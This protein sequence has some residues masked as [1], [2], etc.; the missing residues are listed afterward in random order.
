MHT[1][2]PNTT[3]KQI[4]CLSS[5]LMGPPN[6]SQNSVSSLFSAVMRVFL[7]YRR[8]TPLPNDEDLSSFLVEIGYEDTP[9]NMGDLKK[10]K[11]PAPWHMVVHYVLR[12]LS[13]KTGGTD[14]IVKDLLRL[15]WGVYRNKNIDFVGIL[16]NDFKQFVLAKKTE[17][18]SARFWSVI[19][20]KIYADHPTIAP[21][22]DD[23][24]YKAPLLSKY[25]T[26]YNRNH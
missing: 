22:E 6:L 16:W 11:F 7:S 21:A 26:N 10:A 25:S 23:V 18:P 13:E 4:L 19:L 1:K 2:R 24:M 15:L 14:T 5:W 8:C 9:P 3:R 17:V 12:C 20:N